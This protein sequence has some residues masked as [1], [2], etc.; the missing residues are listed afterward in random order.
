M[1]VCQVEVVP[2]GTGSP[3]VG[4]YVAAVLKVLREQFSDLKV[5]LTPMGTVLE[6]DLD[7]ILQAVKAAHQ[8]PFGMGAQRVVTTVVIDE[9]TDKP[10]SAEGKLASVR[11]RLGEV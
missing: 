10:L 4:D 8:A 11:K 7:R 5:Q 3:S 9:R 1:A 6:G 2:V